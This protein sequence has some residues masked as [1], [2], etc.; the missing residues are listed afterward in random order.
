VFTKWFASVSRLSRP[1]A[2][3]LRFA[4]RI[5]LPPGER[6]GD[7]QTVVKE[8]ISRFI[9]AINKRFGLEQG[10]L[11]AETYM[12]NLYINYLQPIERIQWINLIA[13]NCRFACSG[14]L[15]CSMDA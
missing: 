6:A 9:A 15:S 8:T 10:E 4:A 13:Q 1:R 5:A 3:S 14:H 2:S 12:Y 7:I 11:V